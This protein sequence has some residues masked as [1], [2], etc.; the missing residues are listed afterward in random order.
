M[1]FMVVCL[2]LCLSSPLLA[3][4]TDRGSIG[5]VVTDVQDSAVP[6]AT[7]T[8]TNEETGVE[9]VLVT[10]AS[11][12]YNSNPLVLGHYAVTVNLEGF[13]TAQSTEID[14]RAG[15]VVR[16][17]V[18]LEVGAVTETIEVV[19]TNGGLD[20]TRPDVSHRWTRSST[21]ISRSSPPPTSASPSPCF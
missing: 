9:I 16:H 15:D 13:K 8:V 6:G 18:T 12:A 3:Q 10:N 21:A 19:S 5:G 20:V 1:V 14:L 11:G 17:D 4:R 2:S 7:V